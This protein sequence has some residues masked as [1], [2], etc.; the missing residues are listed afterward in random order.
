MV[1]SKVAY[2]KDEEKNRRFYVKRDSSKS[3]PHLLTFEVWKKSMFI[4]YM[5]EMFI[6]FAF[7]LFF[8]YEVTQFNTS[9]HHM[10]TDLKY[11]DIYESLYPETYMQEEAWIESHKNLLK[12][13]LE[14]YNF[15]L[16]A[17]D[18]ALVTFTLPIRTLMVKIFTKKTLRNYRFLNFNTIIDLSLFLGVFIWF[19]RY[20]QLLLRKD[21]E[22]LDL[23][24][25]QQVILNLVN[26]MDTG[27]FKFDILLS[28]V[29]GLFWLKVLFFFRLTRTFGPMIKIIAAMIKEMAIF[30]VI[31]FTQ[32]CFL[33]CV[34]TLLFGDLPVYQSF[35]DAFIMLLETALG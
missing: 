9:L 3:R 15:L 1:W 24:H 26:D 2:T 12:D 8:Q 11:Q 35:F 18:I 10:R 33:T 29:V 23:N 25:R 17:M 21:D 32:L 19:I 28:F 20:E 27:R 34:S 5:L 16:Y 6:F 14:T 13:S 31:W 30:C 22:T 4:R 7:A